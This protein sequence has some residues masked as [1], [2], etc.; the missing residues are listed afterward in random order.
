[1][2]AL[3]ILGRGRSFVPLPYPIFSICILGMFTKP[4]EIAA[5]IPIPVG[6]ISSVP[7]SIVAI[8]IPFVL[9]SPKQQ[10]PAQGLFHALIL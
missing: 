9:L 2:I 4:F 8:G 1:M 5:A 7:I 3:T 6:V 10:V